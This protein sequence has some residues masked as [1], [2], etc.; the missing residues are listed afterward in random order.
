MAADGVVEQDEAD[1]Q[2]RSRGDRGD[3]KRDDGVL[4][5]EVEDLVLDDV[6]E[7]GIAAVG[8]VAGARDSEGF[9]DQAQE[10]G[11]VASAGEPEPDERGSDGRG[12]GAEEDGADASAEQEIEE[13]GRSEVELEVG[14]AGH[15]AAPIGE[16]GGEQR[17]APEQQD[18]QPLLAVAEGHAG[19]R[20]DQ[21][22]TDDGGDAAPAEAVE[23]GGKDAAGDREG[24]VEGEPD[25]LGGDEGEKA[26]RHQQEIEDGEVVGVLRE[27]DAAVEVVV[28]QVVGP[29]IDVGEQQADAAPLKILAA[30]ERVFRCLRGGEDR[31]DEEQAQQNESDRPRSQTGEALLQRHG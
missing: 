5:V 17:D 29:G 30:F 15:R 28:L 14:D 9:G 1:Q 10:F 16:P 12:H 24:D 20:G 27:V 4:Q 21:Q 31:E 26:Q 2:G 11:G 13:E 3:A 25:H 18:K 8:E 19:G 6:H 7:V 22:E 23:A